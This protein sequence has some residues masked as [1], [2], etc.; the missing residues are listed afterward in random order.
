MLE[1]L[2]NLTPM[3]GLLAY[4]F[5]GVIHSICMLRV[6]G[7]ASERTEAFLLIFLLTIVFPIAAAYSVY[8]V[9]SNMLFLAVGDKAH[10]EAQADQLRNLREFK[11]EQKAKEKDEGIV[12]GSGGGSGYA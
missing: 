8:W 5:L 9:V 4:I 7:G 12:D 6:S 3:Q 10:R 2:S 1:Q 11:A